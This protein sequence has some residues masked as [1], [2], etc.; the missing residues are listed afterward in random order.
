M[1]SIT[2]E[3]YRALFAELEKVAAV[4]RGVKNFRRALQLLHEGEHAFHGAGESSLRSLLRTRAVEPGHLN[5]FSP[6]GLRESYWGD[7]LP[8]LYYSV[9][10]PTVAVPRA[11]VL[12]G[13]AHKQL[14][15]V[16]TQL[17]KAGVPNA[18]GLRAQL[19]PAYAPRSFAG[20][21]HYPG[22]GDASHWVATPHPVPLR[23]KD[24]L[25]LGASTKP[26]QAQL[27]QEAG[28]RVIDHSAFTRALKKLYPNA[29]VKG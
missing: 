16:V 29:P 19:A 21:P 14:D 10:Q 25:I 28:M 24:S 3:T 7:R 6:H 11:R 26:E 12:S 20:T 22:Q 23:P 2:T 1:L 5:A 4:P 8:A 15:E 9:G 13:G 18:Q 17:G 27:A